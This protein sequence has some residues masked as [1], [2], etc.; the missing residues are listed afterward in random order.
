MKKTLKNFS[1]TLLVA[2]GCCAILL[3]VC[4]Q[5]VTANAEGRLYSETDSVP[6]GY[7][8][9]L[10]LGTTPQTRFSHKRNMFF[11][12][13]IHATARLYHAGKIQKVLISG[14]DN[15]LD[16]INEV[17]CMKDSLITKGIP[18]EAIILDGKGY[19]TIHS[20]H[21]AYHN[22]GCRKMIVISQRFHN[23][24][25]IYLA[26]HAG[27]GFEQIAGFNAESPRSLMSQRTYIREWF[28]RVKM[29]VDLLY[30]DLYEED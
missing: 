26:E 22:Y 18:Q 14:D 25:A 29:F 8:T 19:R 12:Y 10:L 16:G 28:A 1:Y 17:E 9:G 27:L 13:R 5:L 30:Y 6:D 2:S 21:R 15:S 7:E 3:I 20:I 24:R 11:E 4:N 23:E